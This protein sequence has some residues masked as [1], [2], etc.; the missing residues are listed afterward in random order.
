[1]RRTRPLFMTV[2][3]R[4]DWVFG[5]KNLKISVQLFILVGGLMAAFAV[6]TYFEVRSATATIYN[7]RNQTLRTEI[8]TALSVMKDFDDRA[9]AGEF[10]VEEA[11]KR[12]YDLL[13]KLRYDPMAI[14][15]AMTMTSTCSSTSTRSGRAEFQGKADQTG[16]AYRDAIVKVGQ[17]GGGYVNLI[18]PKPART[19]TTTAIPNRF[20]PRP[21]SH[22]RRSSLP[23]FM[24]MT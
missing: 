10:T 17:E 9:K 23:A 4:E 12:A 15:S 22:G 6:A 21:M 16:F 13:S 7:E 5:M 2:S 18:G 14:S 1:M 8:E 3:R 11:K 24:S 19:R 20:M